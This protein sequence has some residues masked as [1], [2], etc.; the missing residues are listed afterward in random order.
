M[1]AADIG[2]LRLYKRL[3]IEHAVAVEQLKRRSKGLSK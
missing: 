1:S 2:R 3:A